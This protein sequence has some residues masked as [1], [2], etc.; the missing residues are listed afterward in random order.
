MLYLHVATHKKKMKE[1]RAG[2]A[3]F[4]EA[5]WK[6]VLTQVP[7]LSML[8]VLVGLPTRTESFCFFSCWWA[9][10]RFHQLGN[11][12]RSSG[13]THGSWQVLLDSS[14]PEPGTAS[15]SLHFA[16]LKGIRGDTGKLLGFSRLSSWGLRP[17][18]KHFLWFKMAMSFV[19]DCTV[20]PC[21]VL[22]LLT[23]VGSGCPI[24]CCSSSQHCLFFPLLSDF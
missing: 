1:T 14:K 15:G 22:G 2:S 8:L 20:A 18:N 12:C 5:L 3:Q 23:H 7:V 24:A 13:F 10:A 21:T 16:A 4:M 9:T 6:A 11:S 17:R 19:A